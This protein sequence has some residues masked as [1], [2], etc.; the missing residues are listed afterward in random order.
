MY[1][2]GMKTELSIYSAKTHF[3]EIVSEVERTGVHVVICRHKVP[4]AEIVPLH[5][6]SNPLATDPSLRGGVFKGDP[7]APLG[8]DD[9]PETLR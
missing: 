9:W 2:A 1:Y 5:S 7:T 3:S 4:V 6:K 8:P